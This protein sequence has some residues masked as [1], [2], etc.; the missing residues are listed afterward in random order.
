MLVFCD[1]KEEVFFKDGFLIGLW[2]FAE[3]EMVVQNPRSVPERVT[4]Q[5]QDTTVLRQRASGQPFGQAQC[6]A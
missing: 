4:A 2:Q 6:G 5:I 1:F 3:I